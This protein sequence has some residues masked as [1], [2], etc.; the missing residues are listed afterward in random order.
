LKRVTSLATL[1]GA[2]PGALPPLIGWAASTGTLDWGAWLLFAILFVWQI[3]HFLAIAWLYR[4]D[5][6][7]GGL[8][9]LSVVE[10]DGRISGRQAVTYSLALGPISLLPP[11][12]GLAGLIYQGGALALGLGMGLA[13]MR[14]A[15]LRSDKTARI[16]FVVSVVYLA[17]LSALLIADRVV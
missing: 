7:L 10:P 15:L 17:V 5:Y 8:R 12:F 6:R 3:P 1:V 16:L 2:V 13:S 14:F 11:L 4:D 9:T